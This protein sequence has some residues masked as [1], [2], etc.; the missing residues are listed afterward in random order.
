MHEQATV[1]GL[2]LEHSFGA[3]RF[4]LSSSH[5]EWRFAGDVRSPFDCETFDVHCSRE[6]SHLNCD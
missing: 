5:G 3:V 2:F 4:G 6:V 1:P